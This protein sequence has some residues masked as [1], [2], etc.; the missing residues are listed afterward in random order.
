M[1]F[2]K[3]RVLVAKAISSLYLEQEWRLSATKI[4]FWLVTNVECA[5]QTD[6]GMLQNMGTQNVCVSIFQFIFIFL[7]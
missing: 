5:Y 3:L 4:L 1:E 6:D 7:Y 2:S